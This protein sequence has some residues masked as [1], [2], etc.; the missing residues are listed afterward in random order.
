MRL[1]GWRGKGD[2]SAPLIPTIIARVEAN[3]GPY[4]RCMT[5]SKQVRWAWRYLKNSGPDRRPGRPGSASATHTLI[6]AS[7]ERASGLFAGD[8]LADSPSLAISLSWR[9]GQT[10]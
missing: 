2:P 1:D 6:L 4:Y 5:I 7:I 8:D 9:A 3:A 10:V